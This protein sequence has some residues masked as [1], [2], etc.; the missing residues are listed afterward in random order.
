MANTA[1]IADGGRWWIAPAGAVVA[2]AGIGGPV[3]AIA[4]VDDRDGI[5]LT[6]NEAVTEALGGRTWLGALSNLTGGPRADVAVRIRFLDHEGRP[7]GTP[8]GARAAHLGPGGRLHL[9]A[10]LPAAA[11]GLRIEA[12]R[13]TRDGRTVQFGPGAPLVFGAAHG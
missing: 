4:V 8:L 5:G 7:V 1:R 11:T 9:Q 13:W 6:R 2:L 3:L 12:L 10:R